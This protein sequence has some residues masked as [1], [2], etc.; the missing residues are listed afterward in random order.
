MKTVTDAHLTAKH[1]NSYFTEIGPN[2]ANKIEQ[3]SMNFEG[4]TRKCNSIQPEHPLST[5]ELKDAFF[6]LD[7]NKSP[8]FDGISFTV[9]KSF[10][11]ALHKPLLHVFNLS[12]VKRIFGDNLKI[13]HVTPVFKGGDEKDLGNYIPVSVLPCFSKILERIM[14][15]I[16]FIII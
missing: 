10:L 1:F 8:G 7:I 13:G 11:G 9:L 2:L 6:L 4:H 5:N 14:Y 12:I 15:N 3:S 16:D